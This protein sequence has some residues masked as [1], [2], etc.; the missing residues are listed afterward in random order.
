[1][2]AIRSLGFLLVLLSSRV[3]AQ[4]AKFGCS[5]SYGQ[6]QAPGDDAA[7]TRDTGLRFARL[8]DPKEVERIQKLPSKSSTGF[9]QRYGVRRI[10]FF[11][12]IAAGEKGFFEP[13]TGH[14]YAEVQSWA[15]ASAYYALLSADALHGGGIA[16][17][18]G[19]TEYDDGSKT[20]REIPGWGLFAATPDKGIPLLVLQTFAS[21]FG[22][23][24]GIMGATRQLIDFRGG[25]PRS[26]VALECDER[27]S[28]GACNAFD[29]SFEPQGSL[30]CDWVADRTDFQCVQTTTSV[31]NWGNV[32]WKERF[33]L[34]SRDMMWPAE[35]PENAPGSPYD[36]AVALTAGDSDPTGK[37]IVLPRVGDTFVLGWI[38]S[39]ETGG[40]AITL[41]A[42]RGDNGHLWPRFHVAFGGDTLLPE[43]ADE[44]EVRTLEANEVRAHEIG[45][46]GRRLDA[47]VRV[48]P[49]A[50]GILAGDP[51][52]FVVKRLP[53]EAPGL[54]FFQ[55]LLMQNKHHALFWVGIDTRSRP[56]RGQ[57]LLIA[58]DA[59][60]Y[61]HCRWAHIAD[62]AARAEWSGSGE[63][64]ATMDIEPRR[65]LDLDGDAYFEKELDQETGKGRCPY[66]MDLGW[67]SEKG[68]LMYPK[69]PECDKAAMIV[70]T[71]TISDRGDISA[72]PAT[73][74]RPDQ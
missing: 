19:E 33:Y 29:A 66:T 61:D 39:R 59:L 42:S 52:S 30:E 13:G 50:P 38:G 54:Y 73:M 63:T 58:T 45:N 22:A 60:E 49:V 44:L 7:L 16:V 35:V 40:G 74:A 65:Y 37:R 14:F 71:I 17:T 1:M 41:M 3:V 5:E 23:N 10:T 9:A 53:S 34:L 2:I 69:F 18:S 15:G 64:L 11:A 12:E 67:S 8:D 6:W 48:R 20:Q 24:S 68:W 72:R 4:P 46:Q 32:I 27:S 31:W 62:S 26:V 21:Y 43:R 56:N 57:A 25:Q 70:W 51:M 47:D 55:V 36:W 28:G